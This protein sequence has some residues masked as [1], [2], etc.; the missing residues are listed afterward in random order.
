[1]EIIITMSKFQCFLFWSYNIL[2]Y[3]AT[4]QQQM[5]TLRVLLNELK[6]LRWLIKY[7]LGLFFQLVIFLIKN[8]I[9]IDQKNVS[10]IALEQIITI[11]KYYITYTL[12]Y[13]Y[14]KSQLF[15]FFAN[16]KFLIYTGISL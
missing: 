4:F 6:L 9:Y 13:I 15:R 1:M 2:V 10:F 14:H 12:Y 16:E 3:N 8:K 11:L 5:A 7:S